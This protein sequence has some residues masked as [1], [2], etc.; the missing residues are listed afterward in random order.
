MQKWTSTNSKTLKNTQTE[1]LCSRVH[2]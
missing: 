1:Y 2:N